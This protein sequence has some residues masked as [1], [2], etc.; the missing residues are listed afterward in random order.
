M[1][2]LMGWAFKTNEIFEA[3]DIIYFIGYG[4]PLNGLMLVTLMRYTFLNLLEPVKLSSEVG[5]H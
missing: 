1:R 4:V 5:V 2:V 3:H